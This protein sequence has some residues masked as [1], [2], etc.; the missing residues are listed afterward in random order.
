MI[1]RSLLRRTGVRLRAAAGA[2]RVT[3]AVVVGG[4]VVVRIAGASPEA[5]ARTLL[6]VVIYGGIAL[7]FCVALGGPASSGGR[8][9][10][11]LWLQK[12]RTP[13]GLH[14]AGLAPRLLAGTLTAGMV[15]AAGALVSLLVGSGPALERIAASTPV[16]LLGA[17]VVVATVHASSGFG[18]RPE[19]LMALLFLGALVAPRLAQ[20]L[21]PEVVAPWTPWIELLAL[22]LDE[23]P[24][25]ARFL[26]QPSGGGG[27]DVLVVLRFCAIWSLAGVL[28]RTRPG[29][30]RPAGRRPS[31]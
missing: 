21:V 5:T 30:W 27:S 13:W 15:A 4:P 31:S 19:P 3:F 2:H 6:A 17:P 14:L 24:S 25:A 26:R 1:V 28:A 11:L 10:S 7:P 9:A 8:A 20:V 22:P 16:L 23:L 29:A 18:L 12:P